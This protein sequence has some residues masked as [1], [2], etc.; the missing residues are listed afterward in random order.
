[1]DGL[2]PATGGGCCSEMAGGA[3]CESW[4]AWREHYYWNHMSDDKKQF[5]V[6]MASDDFRNSM[7]VPREVGS[8]LRDLIS[9]SEPVQLEA[10][11]GRVSPVSVRKEFGDVVFR[12]GWNEF[13]DAHHIEENDSILFKY[14]GSSR[15]KVHMFNSA[16]HEKFWSC[17]QPHP[18]EISGGVPPFAHSDHHALKE[19]DPGHVTTADF[20]YTMLPGCHLTKE[21]DQKVLKIARTM[22]SET[23]LYVAAMSKSNVS[24]KNCYVCIPSRLVDS[25]KEGITKPIVQLEAPDNRT[26][27]VEA[28]K[29]SDDLISIELGWSAFVASLQIQENDLLIFRI[30]G[31]TRLEVLILDP[32]GREKPFSC[33]VMGNHSSSVQ[34]MSDDS[35]DIVDLP[36]HQVIDISSSDE[37]DDIMREGTE[38]TRRAQKRVTRSCAKTQKI[39]STSSPSTKSGSGA[40][41][42]RDRACG[43]LEVGS[44][45]LSKN[46]KGP[47]QRP[48][49]LS[50]GITLPCHAVKKIEEKVQ[51]IRSELPIFVKVM[52]IS[53]VAGTGCKTC[54]MLFCAEYARACL[55][56]KGQG[57]FLQL[58]GKK[59]LWETT[60]AVRGHKL[61]KQGRLL[62]GWKEF[63]R[64][65]GLEVGDICLFKLEDTNTFSLKMFVYLIR[66]SEL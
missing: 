39:A 23:P 5:L 50:L 49:I 18:S 43:K 65:N 31:K 57:L 62:G 66:K 14:R 20:D 35:I 25:F 12:S 27:S 61:N 58:E 59:R 56:D 63:C 28:S 30:K 2:D 40:H 52:N 36:P 51:E 17:P 46:L 10:P 41:K 9:E 55:P 21:Q 37:D 32:S 48:Y 11:N 6:V 4:A 13:V 24:L 64:Q 33:S 3:G 38:E 15:F 45:P 8:H 22:R 1:M 60:L 16:G 54:E 42:L 53:S 26:Y 44:K 47:S 34:K 29:H 7:R 19:E